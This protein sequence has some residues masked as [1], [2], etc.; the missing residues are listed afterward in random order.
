[1]SMGNA[2]NYGPKAA[3]LLACFGQW[4]TDNLDAS[5][6]SWWDTPPQP[7]SAASASARSAE[8]GLTPSKALREWVHDLAGEISYGPHR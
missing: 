7:G 1:M 4:E 2:A 6:C 5:S 3:V 8:E